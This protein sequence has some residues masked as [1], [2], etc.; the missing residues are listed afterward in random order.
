VS[1]HSIMQLV[2]VILFTVDISR[3][4]TFYGQELGLK[5]IE[6]TPVD[7]RIR[8]DAGGCVLALHAIPEPIAAGIQIESPPRPRSDT[9]LKL[10]FHVDDIDAAKRALA[11][12]GAIMYDVL[13]SDGV[14]MCDGLDPE[15]N[16]FQITTRSR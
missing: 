10:T 15:G 11:G 2:Q 1:Y 4:A 12:A 9:P 14:A 8:L 6:G 7:G 16:V 3:M 5:L 13:R